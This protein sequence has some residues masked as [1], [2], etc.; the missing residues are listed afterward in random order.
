[1][2]W[3]KGLMKIEEAD[4]EIPEEDKIE[5][6]FTKPGFN[7]LVIFDLDETLIHTKRK[8]DDAV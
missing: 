1:M 3:I 7:K 6:K 2:S 8:G 5:F 4:M